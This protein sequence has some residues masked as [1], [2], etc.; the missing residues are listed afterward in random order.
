MR[1]A[2]IHFVDRLDRTPALRSTCAVP[3]VAIMLKPSSTRSAAIFA[4]IFL[5]CWLT[6][7]NATPDF[8]SMEPALICALTYAL[9]N[10]S[11]VAHDFAGGFHFR[12]ENRVDAGKSRERKHRRLHAVLRSPSVRRQVEL[13]QFPSNHQSSGDLRQRH[14]G[15]LADKRHGS[16]CSRIHFEDIDLAG[17]N[18]VLNVHQA[19][20]VQSA[21]RA[22]Q[23]IPGSS[24]ADPRSIDT[25][26]ARTNCRRNE[27]RLPRCA[28]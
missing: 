10:E 8:G 7:M 14:A 20:D 28:P 4:M 1:P 25:S 12:S 13:A 9:P 15:R 24:S 11:S 26:A 6:L 17:V 23:C 16:R 5:S 27:C 19:H 21:C 22:E 18:G 2:L 3:R